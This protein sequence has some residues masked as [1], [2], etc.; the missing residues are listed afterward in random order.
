M[1]WSD[2]KHA[3]FSD[4]TPWQPVGPDAATANVATQTGKPDSLLSWYRDLVPAA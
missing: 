1:H 3:G 2:G 4:A